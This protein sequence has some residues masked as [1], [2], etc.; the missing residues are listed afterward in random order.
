MGVTRGRWKGAG[1]AL[2]SYCWEEGA[3]PPPGTPLALFDQGIA[4]LLPPP[5]LPPPPPPPSP[6]PLLQFQAFC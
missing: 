3:S 6:S 4:T 2:M 5:P 1:D